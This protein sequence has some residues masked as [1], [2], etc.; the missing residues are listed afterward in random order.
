M[1]TPNTWNPSGAS[2]GG[3]GAVIKTVTGVA[4]AMGIGGRPA[5]PSRRQI[6][7]Y[8]DLHTAVTDNDIRRSR[9]ETDNRIR[10]ADHT[11]ERSRS[12]LTHVMGLA[13]EAGTPVR[14]SE[15]PFAKVEFGEPVKPAPT[16]PESGG[17]AGGTSDKGGGTKGGKGGGT[18]GGKG[19]KG[20]GK[21]GKGGKGGGTKGGGKGGKAPKTPKEK[22]PDVEDVRRAVRGRRISYE[23]A[24]A[25]HPNW[26]EEK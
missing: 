12:H 26:R 5:G 24:D 2:K 10:E 14:R 16:T 15:D 22:A 20:G 9:S 7:A 19:G 3:P 23:A 21:G 11:A 6:R 8:A 25:L 13:A 17:A 1:T 18:K 4:A